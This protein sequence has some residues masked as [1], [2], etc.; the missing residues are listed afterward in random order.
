MR[1]LHFDL[2]VSR[3]STLFFQILPHTNQV[4]TGILVADIWR[5]Q[6]QALAVAHYVDRKASAPAMSFNP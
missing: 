2:S 4:W 5:H 3:L 1:F 6:V